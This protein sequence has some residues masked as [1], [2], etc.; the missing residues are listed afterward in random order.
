MYS[1]SGYGSMIADSVRMDAYVEALRKVVRPGSV[2]LDIG[3]GVGIFA[4]LACRYGAR[5]VYAIEPD[6]V[7][8]VAREIAA[9]NGYAARIEF[10]EGLSTDV[11]LPEP[12]DVIISD[13]RGVLPLF[14]HHIPSI[15]DARKRLLAAGGTLIPM[16]DT[17][18][19]A[20]VEDLELHSSIMGPW[21]EKRYG[22]DLAV[23]RRLVTNTWIKSR[24]LR[25][26]LV[27]EPQLWTTIDYATVD[28]AKVRAEI[29]WLV[30]RPGTAHGLA[31]WFD[32]K[33]V[34]GVGFSNAPGQPEAIYGSAFFPWPQPVALAVGDAVSTRLRADLI[35]TDYVWTLDTCV[36]D[37][38]RQTQIKA[39]F[40][41]STFFGAPLSLQG[42]AKETPPN[43]AILDEAGQMD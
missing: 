2:V 4:L 16:I 33:L 14:Q 41:Q 11:T 32:T 39:C 5:R 23:A 27:V 28:S 42:L 8:Q 29:S 19:A 6:H 17:L 20:I 15:I 9:A 10:F 12:A 31:I 36:R 24:F 21:A 43:V 22:F 13:L 35:G 25:E 7:I 34:D 40:Q 38:G 37:Q 1:L 26:N 18:W 3:T 30:L